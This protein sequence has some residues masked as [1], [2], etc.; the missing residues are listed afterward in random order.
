MFPP[1]YHLSHY[2]TSRQ[3][4]I[5]HKISIYSLESPHHV[6]VSTSWPH[7][8]IGYRKKSLYGIFLEYHALICWQHA[9]P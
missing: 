5:M 1:M 9:V 6:S 4:L 8:E 3:Q 7:F 2:N